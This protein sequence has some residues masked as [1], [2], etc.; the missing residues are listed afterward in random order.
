M[1]DLST[2]SLLLVLGGIAGLGLTTAQGT[3]A[4]VNWADITTVDFVTDE[5]AGSMDGVNFTF[6]TDGELYT[7]TNAGGANTN[8][9]TERTDPGTYTSA[10]VDNGP[11]A[12]DLIAFTGGSQSETYELVFDAPVKDLFMAVLSLGSPTTTITYEFDRDFVLESFGDGYFTQLGQVAPLEN[13]SP[14][15]LR[16]AEAHGLI[17]F[18]GVF[19]SFSWTI[20]TT[21]TWHGIIFGVTR[22]A[23]EEDIARANG[24]PAP[25]GIGLLALGLAAAVTARHRRRS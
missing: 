24:I 4:P 14:G 23:T 10:N 3:A 9:W 19:S 8:Y 13:P 6:A 22:K 20:P 21:E 11:A 5:V 16:G 12:T 17:S 7:T 15:V 2:H 1:K 25:P 18:E